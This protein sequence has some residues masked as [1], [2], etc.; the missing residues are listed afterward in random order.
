MRSIAHHHHRQQPARMKFFRIIFDCPEGERKWRIL[1]FVML[2]HSKNAR[3]I[4]RTR[5]LCREIIF[6]CLQSNCCSRWGGH[7][8]AG[9]GPCRERRTRS[10][11]HHT[12]CARDGQQ[13][14]CGQRGRLCSAGAR[15]RSHALRRTPAN[16]RRKRTPGR[17]P[18]KLK[19]CQ[20]TCCTSFPFPCFLRYFSIIFHRKEIVNR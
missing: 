19:F 12:W 8:W 13:R 9:T 5:I 16:Q 14:L 2:L 10:K 6:F 7:R 4:S 18:C 1:L 3:P 15:S 20:Y 11:P 17:N